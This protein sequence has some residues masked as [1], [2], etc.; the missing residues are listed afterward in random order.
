M[1]RSLTAI[2]HLSAQPLAVATLFCAATVGN[3][4]AAVAQSD[5]DAHFGYSTHPPQTADAADLTYFA[6]QVL[7]PAPSSLGYSPPAPAERISLPSD[8][9]LPP[10]VCPTYSLPPVAGVCGS[11]W[12]TP[13]FQVLPQGVLFKSFIAGKHAER[14]GAEILHS[15]KMGGLIDF[16]VGSRIALARYGTSGPNA[17]GWELQVSGAA[18]PRLS[19]DN[20][21]DLQAVDFR[22]GVPLVYRSGPTAYRFGYDH[23]S[24]HAGDEFLLKNPGFN[25]I[26]YVRDELLFGVSHFLNPDL[27]VYGEF[28]Y[29]FHTDGGARPVEFQFGA[30][31]APLPDPGYVGAPV[32][33]VNT[34]I[35]Q[36][37]DYQGD[38]ATVAG[39]Q[40]RGTNTNHLFRVGLSYFTGHS[41]QYA[42]L[43]TYEQLIG[44]GVWYDF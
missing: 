42:F 30:E 36:D 5:S 40:W 12:N 38:F 8:Y 13:R 20:D 3:P 17:E 41:R 29:A 11:D 9:T 43:R 2:W 33:A 18:F 16:T 15:N 39:W 10:T 28:G 26:N 22:V 25:R 4:A 23:I 24:A 21:M 27:Q 1:L 37:F 31:Y 35:R 7:E 44:V 32:L 14:M 19:I 6:P 34:H